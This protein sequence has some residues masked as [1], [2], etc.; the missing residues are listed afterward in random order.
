MVKTVSLFL[1][2]LLAGIFINRSSF[3]LGLDKFKISVLYLILI[4]GAEIFFDSIKGRD[5]CRI[6]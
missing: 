4:E 5:K 2:W 6:L 3:C 1:L